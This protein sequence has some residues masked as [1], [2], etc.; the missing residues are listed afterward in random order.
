[1]QKAYKKGVLIISAAGNE[2]N[3]SHFYPA[4]L[5]GSMSVAAVDKGS[6]KAWFNNV[7]NQVEISAPGVDIKS[8]TKNNKY[9]TFSGTSMAAPHV[10]G[11]AGLLWMYFPECSNQQI[12][13][14][15]L[16]SAKS[17]DK[18]NECNKSTGY[19]LLQ[20]IDAYNLLDNWGCSGYANITNAKAKGGCKQLDTHSLSCSIDS[21]CDDNDPCTVHSC[22]VDGTCT[23]SMDCA[24]CQKDSLLT[25]D[26]VTDTFPYETTW[27]VR[28]GSTTY[29]SGGPY[30]EMMMYSS[31]V[32][33]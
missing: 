7:N 21:D 11:V 4:S 14:A 30:A 23:T 1:V 5:R 27:D 26:I 28:A 3:E 16:A 13:N 24:Q 9:R 8:T 2:A 20:A 6:K 32:C 22:S 12:R 29:A 18:T 31:Y 19:G 33:L 15:I 17:L 25:I 10:A